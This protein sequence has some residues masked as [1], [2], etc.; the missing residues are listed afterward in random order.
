MKLKNWDWLNYLAGALIF[1][2]GS[3]FLFKPWF[4]YF[5][6]MREDYLSLTQQAYFFI[7]IIFAVILARKL[8]EFKKGFTR[9]L[10]TSLFFLTNL[11]LIYFFNWTLGYFS[12]YL[13]IALIIAYRFEM[14]FGGSN[15]NRD[16][17]LGIL[18]LIFTLIVN[19]RFQLGLDFFSIIIIF[20][21]G[22]AL[23]V[24]FNFENSTH[25]NKFKVIFASIF[26]A[27]G[28]LFLVAILVP[29]TT[30]IISDFSS[31]FLA[32]YY[33]LVDIFLIIIYPIIWLLGPIIKF[34]NF[35]MS[36][37]PTNE[38]EPQPQESMPDPELEKMLEQAGQR[39]ISTGTNFW[40]LYI[41]LGIILIYLSFK[42]WKL[43]QTTSEEGF[44][45]ERESIFDKETFKNDFKQFVSNIKNK[46]IR[47]QKNNIYDKSTI[48]IKI[49]EIYYH[50]LRY[51]NKYKTYHL[52]E[53]PNKYLNLL[54]GSGY[55]ENKED[56]GKKL[57]EIYNKVRYKGS[58]NEK[59]LKEAEKSWEEINE[60]K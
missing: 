41:I 16:F 6:K 24:F 18:F 56:D 39:D 20:L 38:V 22:I 10:L 11:F 46:F 27:G 28:I 42:L 2:T 57:T 4:N 53:T 52:S 31:F 8:T 40:W 13:L 33:K 55:L 34:I 30:E 54:L 1:S 25:K 37:V 44:R 35:L 5:Y 15:Y 47:K 3:F 26:L 9:I 36:K 29:G 17:S 45:E 60:N 23:S 48:E 12:L 58:A 21:S 32:A 7:I 49:R 50:Y 59:D 43:K 19:N 14:Y 51:Y